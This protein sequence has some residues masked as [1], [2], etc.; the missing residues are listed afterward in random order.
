MFTIQKVIGG[1]PKPLRDWKAASAILTGKKVN[2]LHIIC[3]GDVLQFSVN[4]KT[5][6]TLQDDSLTQGG[7][8]LVAGTFNQPDVT[9]TFD[10]L[11]VKYAREIKAEPPTKTPVAG[12]GGGG[13]GECAQR[14][15]WLAGVWQW[16]S[17]ASHQ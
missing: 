4:D 1:S 17:V 9:V 8:A 14:F 6:A 10:N 3:S 7:L 15:V 12:V 2:T 11:V 16:L 5:L 13:D